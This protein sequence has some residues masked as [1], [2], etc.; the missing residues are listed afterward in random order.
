MIIFLAHL[1]ECVHLCGM[2]YRTYRSY[3]IAVVGP[4]EYR[5]E[6][7]T[8]TFESMREAKAFIDLKIKWKIESVMA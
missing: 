3:R 5:V 7:W 4:N 1:R 2:Q 6:Y 8:T